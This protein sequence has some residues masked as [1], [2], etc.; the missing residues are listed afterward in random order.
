M[1][2]VPEVAGAQ[3]GTDLGLPVGGG[4][5]TASRWSRISLSWPGWVLWSVCLGKVALGSISWPEWPPGLITP[6]Q[7]ALGSVVSIVQVARGSVCV[8]FP[9]TPEASRPVVLGLVA[10]PTFCLW[11]HLI[12]CDLCVLWTLEEIYPSL[13]LD[14]PVWLAGT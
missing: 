13:G 4:G 6:W 3:V 9:L 1:D 5:D 10:G 7:V 11:V 8:P 12:F 14:R 2:R